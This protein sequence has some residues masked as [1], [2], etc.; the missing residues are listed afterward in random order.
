MVEEQAKE[1]PIE[2]EQPR[3]M[4]GIPRIHRQVQHFPLFQDPVFIATKYFKLSEETLSRSPNHIYYVPMKEQVEDIDL[5]V[6]TSI[7][8]L[9]LAEFKLDRKQVV[10]RL[11]Q[12]QKWREKRR[13]KYLLL[14]VD[15]KKEEDCVREVS[16]IC[17]RARVTLLVAWSLAQSL[18][19]IRNLMAGVDA[20]T[21]YSLDSENTVKVHKRLKDQL[22]DALTFDQT[23][24]PSLRGLFSA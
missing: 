16:V 8:Y 13:H 11:E 3:Q 12:V 23:F 15:S 2:P 6:H 19:Y 21:K 22:L 7:V 17:F 18:E 9:S 24:F 1:V 10:G 14:Q 20:A 5:N 4:Y